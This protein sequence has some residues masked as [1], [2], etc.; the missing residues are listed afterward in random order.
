MRRIVICTIFL[1]FMIICSSFVIAQSE[2]TEE[3]IPYIGYFIIGEPELARTATLFFLTY[4]DYQRTAVEEGNV[5]V[6]VGKILP[7]VTFQAPSL[8]FGAVIVDEEESPIGEI[9]TEI[10][11]IEVPPTEK[12]GPRPGPGT[13]REPEPQIGRAH[14]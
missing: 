12:P 4:F 8:V 3:E 10:P 7:K 11:P 1:T 5:L 13:P 14:V 6:L 2:E 9:P